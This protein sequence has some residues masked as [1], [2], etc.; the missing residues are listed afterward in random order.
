MGKFV[1]E[2]SL[3]DKKELIV[4]ATLKYARQKIMD[5]RKSGHWII[6]KNHARSYPIEGLVKEER[7]LD[8]DVLSTSAKPIVFSQK[9]ALERI[10]QERD[11]LELTLISLK[12][13]DKRKAEWAKYIR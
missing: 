13:F 7:I 8:D 12:E 3:H 2:S 10:K 11:K 1:V 4:L 6:P 5:D 9:E